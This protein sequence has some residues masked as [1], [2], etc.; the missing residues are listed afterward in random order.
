[1]AE[2][3]LRVHSLFSRVIVKW[4]RPDSA[5]I[6]DIETVNFC[7]FL[8]YRDILL[9]QGD[10]T[11]GVSLFLALPFHDFRFCILY[12]PFVSQFF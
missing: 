10:F 5:G 7:L 11:F 12:K 6:P 8:Q 1:M 4:G 2:Y 9:Q 3:M